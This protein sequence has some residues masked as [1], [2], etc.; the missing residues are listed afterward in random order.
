MWFNFFLRSLAFIVAFLLCLGCI[1]SEAQTNWSKYPGN[2]VVKRGDLGEFDALQAKQPTV[3]F[4]AGIF[5][6]WYVGRNSSQEQI[7]YAESQDGI[8][9]TK[10]GPVLASGSPGEF[11]SIHQ[12]TP[13]V[14]KIGLTYF[15]WYA[16]FNGRQWRIGMAGSLDGINWCKKGVVLAE[17]DDY[18]FDSLHVLAPSVIFIDS[19]YWMWYEGFDGQAWRIGLAH[20]QD[21]RCWMKKGMVL[22][23]GSPFGFDSVHVAQPEVIFHEGMFHLWYAGFNGKNWQLGYAISQDGKDWQKHG[24]IMHR[25]SPGSFDSGDIGDCSVIIDRDRY[26]MWYEGSI[27]ADW[28]IGYAFEGAPSKVTFTDVTQQ[29]GLSGF[30]DAGCAFG[31]FNNDG[32]QDIAIGNRFGANALF[33][34]QNGSRF[35]NIASSA[36]VNCPD[37]TMGISWADFNNDGYLDI[38]ICNYD[39]ANVLYKNI[40]D[41]IFKDITSS[42]GVGTDLSS[43][44]AV[45]GDY[46]NDGFVDIYVVNFGYGQPNIL[47]KNNGDETFTDVTK[48]ANIDGHPEERS[49]NAMWGDYDNDGFID[50]FVVNQGQ[51]VLYRNKGNGSFYDATS[52]AGIYETG[53]GYGCAWADYNNDGFLDLYV[54]NRDQVGVLFSNNGEGTFR[55]VTEQAGLSCV[56]SAIGGAWADI[57]NDGDL[58]LYVTNIWGEPNYLFINNGNGEFVRISLENIGI[59]NYPTTNAA[60]GDYNNDGAV[61]LIATVFA[62]GVLGPC[63]Y[64]NQGNSNHWL[65]ANLVGSISNRSA[66]GAKVRLVAGEH[67]Q[68][69]EVSGGCGNYTFD[70]LPVEFGLGQTTAIDSLIIKWPSGA[71][72]VMTDVEVDQILTIEELPLNVQQYKQ[73][74]L[75]TDFYLSQNFP[76]PFNP[77]TTIAFQLPVATDIEISIYNIASE[78]II[79]LVS[80]FK[81]AGNYQAVWNGR[82]ENNNRVPSGLYW[83]RLTAGKFMQTR[84]MVLLR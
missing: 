60:F 54:S 75:L 41:G 9:W 47:Y 80:G 33:M 44:H 29:V 16:G 71:I 69:R 74:S 2:P 36:G 57:D 6:M 72:H 62:D 50:L 79:T 43:H 68:Y 38:Y 78:K 56:K 70:S 25:G 21:G 84:K 13:K 5:K 26:K 65:F 20:S 11:D 52:A 14:L 34:N 3:I 83:Y 32:F 61:D 19:T 59:H 73:P 66:I 51:D 63:L 77:E 27:F 58:D 15:M 39:L 82:D 12:N 7:G 30:W 4:D 1:Q 76:N 24:V 31:D 49:R 17:G 37:W 81:N 10:K 48:F 64:R 42:A 45:W 53:N 67:A 35:I 55:A 22:D 28:Q 8:H 23:I 46:D 40:G 18:E